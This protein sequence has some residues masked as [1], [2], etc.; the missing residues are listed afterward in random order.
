MG[1]RATARDGK[2][3]KKQTV[4]EIGIRDFLFNVNFEMSVRYPRCLLEILN[5]KLAIS[6]W[7]SKKDIN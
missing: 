7:S 6:V 4:L 3:K 1:G 2:T 5:K